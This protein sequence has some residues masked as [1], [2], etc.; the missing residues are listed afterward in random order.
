MASRL[1]PSGTT[2]IVRSFERDIRSRFVLLTKAITQLLVTEDALGLDTLPHSIVLHRE[3]DSPATFTLPT[4]STGQTYMFQTNA[5]REA[6][7]F[8]ANDKKIEAF[9]KW[10][11]KQTQEK[12]LSTDGITG[13][14]WTGKYVE[15][16]YKKGMVRAYVDSKGK[17]LSKKA[18]FFKGTKAQFLQTAFNQPE[19][20][21]KVRLLATR[22][23]EELR[24][25]SNEA[26][27]KLNRILANGLV[28]GKNPREIA[29]DM[30]KE[31]EGLSKAR[32]LRIA[33]TEII[34][35]HAEGQLD[36]F[37]ELGVEGVGAYAE[38]STA[39]DEKVCPQCAELEGVI[40][41][42]DEARGLIPRHPNCR[43]AWLPVDQVVFRKRLQSVTAKLS[44]SLKTQGGKI[45]R[46][47]WAGKALLRKL[48]KK[49][50]KK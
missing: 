38:W 40:L 10:L 15:S 23:F 16:A 5:D 27:T 11:G 43:C 50:R 25:I 44:K 22:S 8:L 34:H 21:A 24:G 30:A 36:S 35:A 20:L 29:K 45:T 39:G 9:N 42:I 4:W 1:D 3:G 14:P 31:I 13:K 46:S 47:T 26:A 6:W 12:L 7:R 19:M 17:T 2:G 33:R 32:A 48:Q 37:Q 18:E 49:G 28:Q 41:T